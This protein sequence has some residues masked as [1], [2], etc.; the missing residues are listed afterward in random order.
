MKLGTIF[1]ALSGAAVHG[2]HAHFAHEQSQ[3]TPLESPLRDN[4][5]ASAWL[6]KY[7]KQD[8]LTYTGPLSFSHIDYA[9]CL[10]DTSQIFDIAIL[11]MPFD[12]AVTH[13]PGARF[14]PHGIRV[15]SRRQSAWRAYTLSWGFDPYKQGLKVLDCG[16]V[17]IPIWHLTTAAL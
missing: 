2:A 15:G 14:G 16:D 8:D 17:C 10:E 1:L 11:G 6:L 13:R 7:G 3:Q 9:R 4:D 5:D 12:T